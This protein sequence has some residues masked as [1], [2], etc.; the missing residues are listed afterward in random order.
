MLRLQCA[1]EDQIDRGSD[2]TG[3]VFLL[4]LQVRV[5]ALQERA[6]A[7]KV[8]HPQIEKNEVAVDCGAGIL[9]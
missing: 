3:Q 6:P 5:P 9:R 2:C 4:A 7:L 1:V 8:R